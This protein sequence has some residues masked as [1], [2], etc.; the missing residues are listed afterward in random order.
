MSGRTPEHPVRFPVSLQDWEH[1]TF[2][3]W[4]YDVATVQSL[5]PDELTVQQWDGL[6]WVGVTPFRMVG[7]RAPGLPPPPGWGAFPEL[8]VRAYV[9]MQDGRDGI[10]FLGMVVPRFSFIVALRSLGLPYEHSHSCVSVDGARWV[11][12]FGTPRWLRSRPDDWFQAVVDVGRP[13]EAT[14]RT[15]LVE[16]ITGRWSAYHRR[17]R[18]LWRTPVA[19]EPWPLHAATATGSLTTPLRWVGLPPP[20]NDPLVHAAPAVHAGFGVPRRA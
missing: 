1:L 13:L 12:R 20:S 11:Y 8:N 2:L 6:T 9:R 5:V 16:S 17:G 4:S 14:E 15:P 3:H 19:H 18:V 10:W 7:V